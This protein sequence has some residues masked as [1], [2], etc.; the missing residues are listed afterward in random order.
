MRLASTLATPQYVSFVRIV[1]GALL[2]IGQD[3]VGGL[4]F[5]EEGGGALGV[6]IVAVGVELE[7][8]SAVCFL[9]PR[10]V[11]QVLSMH[12]AQRT[13]HPWQSSQGPAARSSS[14]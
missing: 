7:G 10:L 13:L 12:T 2:R 5:G 6:A 3:L 8:F 4:D 9:D 1:P 11:S 14:S